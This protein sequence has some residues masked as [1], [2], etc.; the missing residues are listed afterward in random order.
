MTDAA[1]YHSRSEPRR[2][3]ALV[4]Q[5]LVQELPRRGFFPDNAAY[6]MM[7]TACANSSRP[8]DALK[9]LHLMEQK[10]HRV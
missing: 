7:V 6:A 1:Q 5:A 10:G 2:S 8:E 9:C 4:M 3:A